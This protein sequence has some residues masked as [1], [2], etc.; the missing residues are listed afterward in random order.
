MREMG[1]SAWLNTSSLTI[2]GLGKRVNV[3]GIGKKSNDWILWVNIY[4]V[5]PV[6]GR[7]A[8]TFRKNRLI[9]RPRSGIWILVHHARCSKRL[10]S[11]AAVS[12]G[13]EAYSLGYV[14]EPERYENEAGRLFQHLVQTSGIC[15]SIGPNPAS[16]RSRLMCEKHRQ[17][18][19]FL[20]DRGEGCAQA[21]TV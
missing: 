2:Q 19:N 16:A 21:T 15:Q 8:E 12:E 17:P 5:W 4:S 3:R 6:S 14:E 13:P 20:T 9:A 1:Q 18:K 11:K 10:F 7:K